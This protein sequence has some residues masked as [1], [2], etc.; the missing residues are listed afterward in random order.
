[1]QVQVA[2]IST[3]EARTCQPYLGVHIRTVHVHLSA[4]RMNDVHD[5]PYPFLEHPMRGGVGHHQG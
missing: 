5:F 2:D 4:M 3:Y 1:M